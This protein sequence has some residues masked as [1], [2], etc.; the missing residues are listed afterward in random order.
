MQC[1]FQPLLFTTVGVGA[2]ISVDYHDEANLI[3]TCVLSRTI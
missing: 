1:Q 3:I 2:F